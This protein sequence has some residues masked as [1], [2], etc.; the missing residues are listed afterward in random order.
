[1][2]ARLQPLLE[3]AALLPPRPDPL[4]ALAALAAGERRSRKV[5]ERFPWIWVSEIFASKGSP[6]CSVRSGSAGLQ[7]RSSSSHPETHSPVVCSA[8]EHHRASST[9]CYGNCFTNVS[10]NQLACRSLLVCPRHKASDLTLARHASSESSYASRH[11][12]DKLSVLSVGVSYISLS[13]N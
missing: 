8:A 9:S 5:G 11:T 2:T 6:D 13:Q 7:S 10:C 4:A 3:A 12:L 1:M